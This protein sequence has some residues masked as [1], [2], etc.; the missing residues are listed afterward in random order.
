MCFWG[1]NI[2]VG[3]WAGRLRQVA[4]GT[5]GLQ[6]I[7]KDFG[8][9]IIVDLLPT[10]RGIYI[11]YVTVAGEYKL[12]LYDGTASTQEVAR[13]PRGWKVHYAVEG[14]TDTVP[15]FSGCKP[16]SQQC[17]CWLDGV[18]YLTG[19]LPARDYQQANGLQTPYRTA[20]WYYASGNSGI[21]WAAETSTYH[22]W[23]S[24]GSGGI[25][26]VGNGLVA[27]P[28]TMNHR[29]M[30]YDPG[31]AGV[32]PL[33]TLN[34]YPSTQAAAGPITVNGTINSLA[35]TLTL[36]TGVLSV[37]YSV[38]DVLQCSGTGELVFVS[39]WQGVGIYTVVR[40]YQNTTPSDLTFVNNHTVTV[41][42]SARPTMWGMAYSAEYDRLV[43]PWEGWEAL[44]SFW[45][46]QGGQY[47]SGFTIVDL[48]PGPDFGGAVSGVL[49]TSKF[50]FD[51]SL[52]KYFKD[53]MWDGDLAQFPNLTTET[54]GTVDLYYCVDG[55]ASAT[56]DT[57]VVLVQ[58]GA[59][60][61]TRYPV[62]ATGR[63]LQLLAVLNAPSGSSSHPISQGPII[64]WLS[65]RGAPIM[66]GYRSRTWQ[67]ALF[68]D[69]RTKQGFIEPRSGTVLRRNLETLMATGAPV[70]VSDAGMT[71]VLCIIEADKCLFR[72][73]K[74]SEYV[75]Y[76][77]VREV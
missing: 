19:M 45:G 12:F 16:R 52:P 13:L 57:G 41:S 9:G 63:T 48:R 21:V 27:F 8:A 40:G 34:Q 73:M 22:A 54:A 30:A 68:N 75:A 35:T 72:E 58:A 28:D 77:E 10:P 32:V 3:D 62:G 65:V 66:P 74:P 2:Y 46:N 26:V 76:V 5:S 1:G 60:P 23:D 71:N 15:G 29:L 14:Q 69:I 64:N 38:G 42:S 31:T 44:D 51:S 56:T 59:V 4:N 53:V 7:I 55:I 70:T 67:I 25:S 6:T 20:L 17:M 33:A 37:P 49:A 18:L 39:A 36:N 24:G 47:N 50:D 61:G 11:L 43:I